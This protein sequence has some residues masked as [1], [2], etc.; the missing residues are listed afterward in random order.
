MLYIQSFSKWLAVYLFV[1]QRFFSLSCRSGSR[2]SSIIWTCLMYIVFD[3]TII[4]THTHK[5]ELEFTFVNNVCYLGLET[6]N[7]RIY[8]NDGMLELFLQFVNIRKY[9]LKKKPPLFDWLFYFWPMTIF[10]P[11]HTLASPVNW[12]SFI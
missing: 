12:Q 9:L 11:A 8:L 1:A 4:K 5:V 10:S 6:I 7:S 2:R 3:A